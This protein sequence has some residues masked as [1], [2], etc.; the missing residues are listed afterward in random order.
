MEIKYATF[1][2]YRHVSFTVSMYITP[3]G[4]VFLL[5]EIERGA[6]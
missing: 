4:P 1:G 3:A 5:K 2:T 6:G